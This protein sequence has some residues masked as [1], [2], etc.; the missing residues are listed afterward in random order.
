M[1]SAFY[2]YSVD[3]PKLSYE[4]QCSYQDL[5]EGTLEQVT[6][7]RLVDAFRTSEV[8]RQELLQE[9]RV[10]AR[11]FPHS[12][13]IELANQSA[14]LL[15]QMVAEDEQHARNSKP[16]ED[17]TEQERI[18]ELI[19]Q[20]RDQNG[21]QRTIPGGCDVFNDP[22]GKDSPR[23]NWLTRATPPCLSSWTR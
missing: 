8:S 11:R 23:T 17:M 1:A 22:R 19:F 5:L 3:V 12:D 7:W 4:G 13:D 16:L 6:I 14:E 15:R 2:S 20:L 10:F 9:F 21:C 18:A